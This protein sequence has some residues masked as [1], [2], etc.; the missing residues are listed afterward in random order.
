[1][2]AFGAADRGHGRGQQIGHGGDVGGGSRHGSTV[3][4]STVRAVAPPGRVVRL[5]RPGGGR[6][7]RWKS[8]VRL[9]GLALMTLRHVCRAGAVGL[10]LTG[11]LA[12]AAPASA[13]AVPLG[14]GSAGWVD[15]AVDEESVAVESVAP[16]QTGG[17]PSG[18]SGGVAVPGVVQYGEA[19]SSCTIDPATGYAS[20]AVTGEKF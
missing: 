14:T 6:C 13:A 3:P 15:L 20:V 9:R 1:A 7:G 10:A 19:A 2:G 5:S 17:V 16:C 8:P 4:P 18:E 12:T 11:L